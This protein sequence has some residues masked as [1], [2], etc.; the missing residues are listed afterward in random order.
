MWTKHIMQSSQKKNN[1]YEKNQQQRQQKSPETKGSD[2][3]FMPMKQGI[4]YFQAK[5]KWLNSSVSFWI[6]IL[7]LQ[8]SITFLKPVSWNI[9]KDA[10]E[11]LY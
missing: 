5:L 11:T 1:S 9:M 10:K 8:N 2:I 6:K 3:L 4:V 7:A